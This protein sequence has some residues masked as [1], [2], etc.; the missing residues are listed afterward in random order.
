MKYNQRSP[1]AAHQSWLISF[2][3][4]DWILYSVQIKEMSVFPRIS[5]K[6]EVTDFLQGVFL[7]KEV[8]FRRYVGSSFSLLV[9][10]SGLSV[11]K[12]TQGGWRNICSIEKSSDIFFLLPTVDELYLHYCCFLDKQCLLVEINPAPEVTRLFRCWLQWAGRRQSVVSRSC[13]HACLTLLPTLVSGPALTWLPWK[14]SD[15]SWEKSL[16]RWPFLF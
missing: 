11:K 3:V 14:R 2:S 7:N 12:I 8:C 13:S 15:A 4:T 1:I 5:L 16:K 6:P 10:C 9:N